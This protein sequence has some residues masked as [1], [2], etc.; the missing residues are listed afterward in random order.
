MCRRRHP[1]PTQRSSDAESYKPVHEL[2]GCVCAL[3]YVIGTYFFTASSLTWDRHRA[4]SC[5]R[6]GQSISLVSGHS[7]VVR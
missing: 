3:P 5:P 2:L 4:I 7:A 6:I 1:A